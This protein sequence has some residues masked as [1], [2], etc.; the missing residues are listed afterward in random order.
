MMIRI[1][2]FL[3]VALLGIIAPT[4]VFVVFALAYALRYTA[5]ELMI[6]A[7]SIDAYYGL[8]YATVPYYTIATTVGLLLIEWIKPRIS[9]YNE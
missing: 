8:G 2:C 4:G 7:V 5:Y 1:V 6:I 3:G 9:V